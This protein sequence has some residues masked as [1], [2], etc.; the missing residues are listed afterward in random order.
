MGGDHL[1]RL[2]LGELLGDLDVHEVVGEAGLRD[3]QEIP[4]GEV[5]GT[6]SHASIVGAAAR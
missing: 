1:A 6:I 5:I 2:A 3:P 4:A